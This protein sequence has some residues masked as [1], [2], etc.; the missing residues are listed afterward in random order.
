MNI[1]WIPIEPGF[2]G[3]TLPMAATLVLFAGISG[4]LLKL[5]DDAFDERA[6]SARLALG[7]CLVDCGLAVMLML[8]R[9]G[10]IIIGAIFWSSLFRGKV[11]NYV[12]Y[13]GYAVTGTAWVTL[14]FIT[15]PFTLGLLVMVALAVNIASLFITTWVHDFFEDHRNP[16]TVFF[17][18][19]R[20]MHVSMVSVLLPFGGISVLGLVMLW[21]F[22]IGY[23]A[24]S[25]VT[26]A[27]GAM[28]KEKTN[29]ALDVMGDEKDVPMDVRTAD[30][31]RAVD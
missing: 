18:K 1:P 9:E 24:G 21:V 15:R 25:W 29:N 14:F 10:F 2:Y 20:F 8:D 13:L 7:L 26:G 3:S 17:I 12:F 16:I 22:I 27:I 11:D 4:L 19:Y 30:G 31:N 6:F 5:V 28:T 23:S